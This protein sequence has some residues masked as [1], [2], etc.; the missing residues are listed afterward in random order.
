[1]S[2]NKKSFKERFFKDI[3]P[4]I[5]GVGAAIVIVGALFKLE[6]WKGAS[7]MLILGLGTE[8]LLFVLGVF[9]PKE[10]HFDW[11]KVY[12]ELAEEV[13]GEDVSAEYD[14]N[15]ENTVNITTVKR[16]NY[17]S[18][19]S[20]GPIG[21][22]LDEMF[23]QAKIDG[24]LINKLGQGMRKISEYAGSVSTIP[25]SISSTEKYIANLDK[26]SEVLVGLYSSHQG[27]AEAV[28]ELVGISESIKDYR[29]KMKNLTDSMGGLAQ[30]YQTEI[31]DVEKNIKYMSAI[32]IEVAGSMEKLKIGNETEKFKAEFIQLSDKISS[33][34]KIY[35]NMLTAWKV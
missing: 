13:G 16:R 18:C 8:A 20:D 31:K 17:S 6:N 15:G 30:V 9:E 32:Y 1:M 21:E 28:N 12:P 26:A 14:E 5:Y 19:S 4:V 3:M 2:R 33:L 10:Q 27:A 24:E 7:D 34:N 22:K 35:G 25:L 29:E 11:T 23:A